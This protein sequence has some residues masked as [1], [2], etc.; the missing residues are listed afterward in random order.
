MKLVLFD[1]NGVYRLSLHGGGVFFRNE[2]E[3]FFFMRQGTV[4]SLEPSLEKEWDGVG[5]GAGGDFDSKILGR[6]AQSIESSELHSG[7]EGVRNGATYDPI[8]NLACL[9][10]RKGLWGENCG[11]HVSIEPSEGF[12]AQQKRRWPKLP[13]GQLSHRILG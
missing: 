12:P 11:W 6:K 7:G 5:E 1:S 8:A 3:H 2:P 13:P 4:P 9:G 10:R